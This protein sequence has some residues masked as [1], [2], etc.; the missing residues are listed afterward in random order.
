MGI[1]DA[2]MH[3]MHVHKA[4]VMRAERENSFLHRKDRKGMSATIMMIDVETRPKL[5]KNEAPPPRTAFRSS[6]LSDFS[7]FLFD[8]LLSAREIWTRQ[9]FHSHKQ[10]PTPL[11]TRR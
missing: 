8:F 7:S 11:F 4:F 6:S 5:T 10:S 3:D 2:T 1:Q 9:N